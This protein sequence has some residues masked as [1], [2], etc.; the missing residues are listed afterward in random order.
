[1]VFEIRGLPVTE[2]FENP[3]APEAAR[4]SHPATSSLCTPEHRA[5]ELRRA[6]NPASAA[7][8]AREGRKNGEKNC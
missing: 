8:A 3:G 1:M 7:A 2:S 5:L 6:N 4:C